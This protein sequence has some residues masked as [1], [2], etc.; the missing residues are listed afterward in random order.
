MSRGDGGRMRSSRGLLC[1][2]GVGVLVALAAALW[3]RYAGASAL[4]GAAVA[5]VTTLYMWRRALVAERTVAAALQ[6]AVVGELIKVVGTIALFAAAARIPH[7]VW[8]ALLLGYAAALIAFW[9]TCALAPGAARRV[10][11]AHARVV[12]R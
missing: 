9:V 4:A 1:Q 5:W 6:R 3:S 10:D 2:A 8:P 12:A 7:L 11:V